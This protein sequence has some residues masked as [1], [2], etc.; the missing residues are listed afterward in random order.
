M[1]IRR[2]IF[3]SRHNPNQYGSGATDMHRSFSMSGSGTGG[4][5]LG[6]AH[7]GAEDDNIRRDA[8]LADDETGIEPGTINDLA[9]KRDV[10]WSEEAK[11]R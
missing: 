5:E 11:D 2:R 10:P 9:N 4:G 6:R 1:N 3:D 7:I 8:G